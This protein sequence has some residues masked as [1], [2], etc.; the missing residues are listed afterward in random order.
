[1]SAYFTFQVLI[2]DAPLSELLGYSNALRVLTS[3]KASF[4]M[5]FQK[6]EGMSSQEEAEAIKRE[7]GFYPLDM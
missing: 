3:G 2:A 4:T 1:L 5:E 7:T 6:Y